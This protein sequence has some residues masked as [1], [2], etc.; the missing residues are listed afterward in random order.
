MRF[1]LGIGSGV[2]SIANLGG[3][4]YGA[5]VE[6][7]LSGDG[8]CYVARS[9]RNQPPQQLLPEQIV[10]R[11]AEG[12]THL[13]TPTASGGHNRGAAMTEVTYGLTP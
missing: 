11:V 2:L 12:R 1:H 3:E 4:S 5:V 13:P 8:S 10:G 9:I 7:H 6:Q